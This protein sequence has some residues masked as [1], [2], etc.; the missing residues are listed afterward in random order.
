M[1]KFL[2]L[3]LSVVMVLSLASCSS[4]KDS[5]KG[6]DDYKDIKVGLICLHNEQSTY[7]KNF[8]D[9]MIDACS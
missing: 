5:D 8:I 9:A 1:K 6:S 3:L 2:A 4:K 7:D